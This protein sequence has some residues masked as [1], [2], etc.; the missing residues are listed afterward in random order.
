MSIIR[1]MA[2]FTNYVFSNCVLNT[3]AYNRIVNDSR[4]NDNGRIKV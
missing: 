1:V 3:L 4:V 2:R